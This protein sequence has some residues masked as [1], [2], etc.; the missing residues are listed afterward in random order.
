MSFYNP[1]ITASGNKHAK[2][3]FVGEAP[4]ETEE[5]T[6]LPFMGGSGQELHLMI[7]EAGIDSREC[8]YTN[9]FFSRPEANK[10][11]TFMVPKK[12]A[13]PN[14]PPMAQGKYVHPSLLPEVDRLKDELISIKP[15]LIVA[16]GNTAAWAL[17]GVYGISRIR[18]VVTDGILVPGI[19]VL[20]TFHPSAILRQYE[21]RPIVVADLF[22]AKREMEFPEIRRPE[23]IVTIDP[24]I[25]EVEAFVAEALQVDMLAVDVETDRG[26]ITHVGFATSPK[27]GFV[28]PF[29]DYTRPG[30]NYWATQDE[31]ARALW[32]V[33]IIL[34]EQKHRLLFQNGLYDIQYFWKYGMP[35]IVSEDTMLLHHSLYPELPKGLEFMGS[36]YTNEASWKLNRRRSSD[37]MNKRDE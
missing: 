14:S 11:Q 31:E 33:R 29:V 20:P 13:P 12:L 26:Q 19:K 21:N 18:G 28:I 24:T 3:V 22:K 1:V 37:T 32:A 8:Y 23:R 9:V 25:E 16:L 36:I 30:N 34:V 7:K 27:R 35:V 2:L 5:L 10:I 15:N 4:G 6:G 17:L